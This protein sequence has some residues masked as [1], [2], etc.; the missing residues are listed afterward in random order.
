MSGKSI[1]N[2][3]ATSNDLV[4]DF[5]IPPKGDALGMQPLDKHVDPYQ[6]APLT[7]KAAPATTAKAATEASAGGEGKEKTL[8][9]NQAQGQV[10]INLQLKVQHQVHSHHWL[11]S[12]QRQQ[13]RQKA[14]NCQSLPL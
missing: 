12:R 5:G 10:V 9:R 11:S 4:L 8:T 7:F 3:A 1:K 14:M 2:E 13:Q 6:Q